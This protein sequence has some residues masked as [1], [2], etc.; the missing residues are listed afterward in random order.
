[1]N[2]AILNAAVRQDFIKRALDSADRAKAE[3]APIVAEIAAAQAALESRYGT[4]RLAQDAR[5]LFGMKAGRSWPGPVLA[6]TTVEIDEN[7]N[8]FTVLAHWRL[9]ASWQGCFADYG[10]LIDSRSWFADA[11]AA[12]RRGDALGFLDGLLV[13]RDADGDVE[14][15]GWSTDPHYR[16]KV[17]GV[18][19]QWRLV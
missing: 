6:L 14:E 4:S 12:A 9:Y 3:G 13:E 17:L 15:P 16:D 1:M 11:A 10:A 7:G 8:P 5:N 19:R 18:A 2:A